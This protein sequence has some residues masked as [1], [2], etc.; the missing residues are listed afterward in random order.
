[1]LLITGSAERYGD[2]QS[3][4]TFRQSAMRAC[5]VSKC[6]LDASCSH[7]RLVN[8]FGFANQGDISHLPELRSESS[9]CATHGVSNAK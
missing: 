9:H 1:M 5:S 6:A 7:C 4:E 2:Q 3:S 8:Y